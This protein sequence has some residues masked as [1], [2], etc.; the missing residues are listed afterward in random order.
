MLSGLLT[1]NLVT[2]M[3]RSVAGEVNG[4]GLQVSN[5][6]RLIVVKV[7]VKDEFVL[8]GGNA[9]VLAEPVLHLVH[10]LPD[11][12]ERPMALVLGETAPEIGGR[13]EVIGMSMSFEDSLD[14]VA[15]LLDQREQAISGFGGDGLGGWIVIQ[16]WVD[17]DGSRGGWVSYDVLPCSRDLFENIVD[18]GFLGHVGVGAVG[19]TSVAERPKLCQ[20]R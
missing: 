3:I 10:A 15:L 14:L 6:E 8:L 19:C 4:R 18:C 2:E 12:N 16:D 11:A 17:D 7:L 5:V 20:V 13:G 1:S 9:V